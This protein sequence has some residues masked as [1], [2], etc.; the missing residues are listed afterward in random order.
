M[1]PQAGVWPQ[2][3][4]FASINH[5][6]PCKTGVMMAPTSLGCYVKPMGASVYI[7]CHIVNT[8]YLLATLKP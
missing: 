2:V 1:A 8:Q 6:P 7:A 3:T 4:H 5:S